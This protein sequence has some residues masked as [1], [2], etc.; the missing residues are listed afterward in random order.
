MIAMH[1]ASVTA[2]NVLA[3]HWKHPEWCADELAIHLNCGSAYV[4]KT[5]SR[6][7]VVVPS[8]VTRRG[9]GTPKD[10]TKVRA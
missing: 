5:L 2:D 8:K 3:A 6:W 9:A 4:R 10:R 1:L 7:R